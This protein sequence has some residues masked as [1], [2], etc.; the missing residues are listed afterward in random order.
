[1][2]KKDYT[3]KLTKVINESIESKA[4]LR[5]SERQKVE[6]KKL[7]AAKARENKRLIRADKLRQFANLFAEKKTILL[8]KQSQNQ[9]TLSDVLVKPEL[10]TPIQISTNEKIETKSPLKRLNFYS[11][12]VSAP[13]KQ[14][15]N[16][17]VVPNCWEELCESPKSKV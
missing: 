3:R 5:E 1:M 17:S 15:E 2:P 4:A 6:R 10:S 16:N 8:Q 14:N 12:S 11:Q 9:N 13:A 7:E